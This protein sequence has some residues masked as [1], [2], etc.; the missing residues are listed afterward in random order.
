M[1]MDASDASSSPILAKQPANPLDMMLIHMFQTT[2]YHHELLHCWQSLLLTFHSLNL[3]PCSMKYIC[4]L[5][6]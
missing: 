6:V 2:N 3:F 4:G 1:W 5:W